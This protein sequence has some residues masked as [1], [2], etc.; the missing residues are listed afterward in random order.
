MYNHTVSC[1]PP[2]ICFLLAYAPFTFFFSL[3]PACIHQDST[4][5]SS[6]PPISPPSSPPL[7]S[8][9]DMG[10]ASSRS[11]ALLPAS[12]TLSHIPTYS[13]LFNTTTAQKVNKGIIL[14][15]YTLTL[16]SLFLAKCNSGHAKRAG[17]MLFF[18]IF[19]LPFCCFPPSPI[20]HACFTVTKTCCKKA[21]GRN[22]IRLSECLVGVSDFVTVLQQGN[23]QQTHTHTVKPHVPPFL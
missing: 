12:L 14:H 6:L 18:P 10:L 16:H 9:T 7:L 23:R 13:L 15:C 1:S 17:G 19:F 11:A 8:L 4:P 22:P 3:C 20:S 21:K 5:S 2:Y